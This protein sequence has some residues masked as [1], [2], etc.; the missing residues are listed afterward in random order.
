MYDV[1]GHGTEQYVEF[2]G[3]KMH[4][5]T[6][7]QIIKD[8]EDYT[9]GTPIRL[10]S[11]STGAADEEGNCTAQWLANM[12]NVEVYAPGRIAYYRPIW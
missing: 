8:R 6:L 12:L 4:N 1:V 9:P 10:L 2:F 5:K 11:C 3:Q 7:V